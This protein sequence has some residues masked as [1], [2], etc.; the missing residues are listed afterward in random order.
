MPSEDRIT[1]EILYNK[2]DIFKK[3]FSWYLYVGM[4]FFIIL[5]VQIFKDSKAI[6]VSIAPEIQL[7][8]PQSFTLKNGMTVMVVENH[9]L[10]R[11]SVTM[12]IDN[13]PIFEGKLAGANDLLG[14]MLGKGSTNIPK[15]AFEE[16]AD[17]MGATLGFSASGA[18]AASLS[19]Y[20]PRVLEMLARY[21][22][23]RFRRC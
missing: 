4:L 22:M 18:Y 13:P 1:A 23:E 8:E 17:F 20:F 12:N 15:N 6:R 9:K 3:L 11:V 14:S 5:L 7:D 10:P 21:F 19:R 2:Y 16:E